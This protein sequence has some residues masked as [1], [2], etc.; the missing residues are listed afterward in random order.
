MADGL[1]VDGLNPAEVVLPVSLT[2][3]DGLL[4][5]GLCLRQ[6]KGFVWGGSSMAQGVCCLLTPCT[7]QDLLPVNMLGD[8]SRGLAA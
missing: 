3:A 1:L 4:P 8:L 6:A 7:A 2:A 5:D